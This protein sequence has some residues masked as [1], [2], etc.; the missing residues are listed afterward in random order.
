MQGFDHK[1][2]ETQIKKTQQ[3]R[4]AADMWAIKAATR[5]LVL[6]EE[7]CTKNPITVLLCLF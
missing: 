2:I 3:E 7:K 5:F 1:T 6:V 4:E